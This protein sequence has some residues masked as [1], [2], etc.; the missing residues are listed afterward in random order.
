MAD[1]KDKQGNI[2]TF[3][4]GEAKSSIVDPYLQKRSEGLL[5]A[6]RDPKLMLSVNGHNGT[7]TERQNRWGEMV[8]F[9][10]ATEA[11][12]SIAN[13]ILNED[14]S[15]KIGNGQNDRLLLD[16]LS[17]YSEGDFLMMKPVGETEDFKASYTHRRARVVG[18]LKTL[19]EEYIKVNGQPHD[20]KGWQTYYEKV[21]GFF[22]NKLSDEKSNSEAVWLK[23]YAVYYL[24]AWNYDFID[25]FE[26][27]EESN[28]QTEKFRGLV[29]T[30]LQ[31]DKEKRTKLLERMHKLDKST[32]MSLEDGDSISIEFRRAVDNLET[33]RSLRE[34]K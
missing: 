33:Y 5:L 24:T 14:D 7:I 10:T 2:V 30:V 26:K 31:L 16:Y 13:R 23:T 8:A 28:P 9:E 19:E 20:E 1:Q 22:D 17:D 25:A 15:T 27:P 18:M 6:K 21:F 12:K 32:G 4:A 34:S 11:G 3:L 29:G